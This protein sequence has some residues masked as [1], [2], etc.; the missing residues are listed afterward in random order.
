[1]FDQPSLFF[2]EP[3]TAPEAATPAPE[4]ETAAPDGASLVPRA[5]VRDM[6]RRRDA[7]IVAFAESFTALSAAAAVLDQARAA[8]AAIDQRCREDSYLNLTREE[9]RH[10]LKQLELP[11]QADF[12]ATARKVVDRRTWSVLIELTDLERIMDKKAKDEMRQALME[13]VP[14]ATEENI[15][16]TLQTFAMDA[17][18]IFKR[19]IANCFT[20]LDRRFRSHDG[21][22]IGGRVILTNAFDE[23]GHWSHY[24]NQRDTLHDI[25]RTFHVLDGDG[26]PPLY[27]GIV[28]AVEASRR[29]GS[30]GRRQSERESEYFTVRGFKN[31]NAHVWFK[32][33]DLVEKVNQLLGEYYGAPIPHEREPDKDTGLHTPKTSLAKNYGFF[34]T[35]DA[36]AAQ[37][38]QHVPLY[39]REGEPVLTVLEPSAG[40]G[41]L[42]RLAAKAGAVVDCVEFQ[43]RL[44]DDLRRTGLYRKV[45]CGDFLTLKPDP[46]R[47]YDRVVMNPP[48]DRERDI[49]HVLHALKFLKPDG[50]LVSIMSASTEFRE[51]RKSIAFRELIEKMHGRWRDLPAGSF[52]SVGTNVN[53]VVLR[54]WN[55]S[56]TQ[57]Y[58]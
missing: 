56:R 23:W 47:L 15:F 22:K 46:A 48:F 39:R 14:E 18:M 30:W 44:A 29:D 38:L 1:M 19:G 9:E 34:P 10:F 50:C 36:A 35:P 25:D 33:D 42:A 53:T 12:V 5:T 51:T 17:D 26:A 8:H 6:V 2:D 21:W 37:V 11:K 31:G 4:P 52:A 7:A 55:D 3:Q 40:T 41:N 28:A 27:S 57:S 45:Q 20:A 49:D 43:A 16:A 54:V 24:G 58:W 32:R 13:N